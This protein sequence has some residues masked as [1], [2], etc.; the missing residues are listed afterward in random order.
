VSLTQG[1]IYKRY[2]VDTGIWGFELTFIVDSPHNNRFNVCDNYYT[3]D[4]IT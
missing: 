1:D 2:D 3:C 4:I